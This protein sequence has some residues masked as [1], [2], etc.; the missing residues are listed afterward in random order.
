MEEKANLYDVHIGGMFAVPLYK[1]A[2]KLDS[3]KAKE[4]LIRL[5]KGSDVVDGVGPIKWEGSLNK[6]ARFENTV[7]MEFVE[8]E[9]KAITYNWME[10]LVLR[11]K[12]YKG[13]S[14]TD[15]YNRKVK[16]E[17]PIDAMV[18]YN[19]VWFMSLVDID[20]FSDIY[21]RWESAPNIRDILGTII[22]K[23]RKFI[24]VDIPPCVI[25]KSIS[26]RL[27]KIKGKKVSAKYIGS[28]K[29]EDRLV[30]KYEKGGGRVENKDLHMIMLDIY[31]GAV[32]KLNSFYFLA[33]DSIIEDDKRG[34]VIEEYEEMCKGLKTYVEIPAWNVFKKNRFASKLSKKV[35]NIQVELVRNRLSQIAVIK[36][37]EEIGNWADSKGIL[38][39]LKDYCKECIVDGFEHGAIEYEGLKGTLSYVEGLLSQHNTMVLGAVAVGAGL[40]GVVIGA[41]IG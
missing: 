7:I 41:M 38:E 8:D 3:K 21:E 13:F 17:S 28:Q 32:Q 34:K 24:P 16:V 15:S 18:I 25:P 23:N 37:S 19:G 12:V 4:S 26:V 1:E 40:I 36:R 22:K 10:P 11:L 33:H 35:S 20:Q 5:L 14:F 27:E 29:I 39:N 2:G 6:A 9:E 31:Y 30:L